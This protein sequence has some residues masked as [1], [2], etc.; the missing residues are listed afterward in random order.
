MSRSAVRGIGGLSPMALLLLLLLACGSNGGTPVDPGVG[1]PATI[2]RLAGD[3][4][5]TTV[6]AA[7]PVQPVAV[8]RDAAG[9]PVPGQQITFTVS[10]GGGWVTAPTVTTDAAGAAAITWYLGPRAGSEQRLQAA[11]AGLATEFSATATALVPG[12]VYFGANQ[13]VELIAGALPLIV[14]APHGGALRPGD[15]PDRTAPGSVTIADANTE[16]LARAVA[17]AF[18]STTGAAPSTIIMRLHRSK[19]D[20]NRDLQDAAQGNAQAA[21]AWREFQGYIEAAR[22]AVVDRGRPGFYID[23]HG[24]GHDLQR[25]E[26]GYM[27]SASDLEQPDAV[28]NSGTMLQK[29][30]VR[31]YVAATS[32]PHAEVIRGSTSLGTLF[33]RNGYPTV[34]SSAQPHPD[35]QPYFSGGYNT[36]RHASQD[37]ALISGVQIEANRI[38]VRDTQENRRRFAAALVDVLR[39]WQPGLLQP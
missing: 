27:L 33:E 25:L 31:A 14:S 30:S 34:P 10:A 2:T 17:D 16:E 36:G 35:R 8:L 18:L 7:V 12:T 26:L 15:I 21:R 20:A 19:V 6:A 11:A 3:G 29:S 32:T 23:L 22:A 1:A 4:Q 13:Y 24:H 28:L 37:G 39:A 5:Q 9:N 38:G